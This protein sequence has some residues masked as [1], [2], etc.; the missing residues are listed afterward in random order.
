MT[1]DLQ[2]R[3]ASTG[4]NVFGL[5]KSGAGMAGEDSDRGRLTK[6]EI[7]YAKAEGPFA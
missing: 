3:N 1:V 6:G 7:K 2:E 4:R 5:G